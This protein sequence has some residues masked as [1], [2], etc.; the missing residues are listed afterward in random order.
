MST[1]CSFLFETC[2]Y[3][4][5]IQSSKHR[6]M[7]PPLFSAG[8]L[9]LASAVHVQDRLGPNSSIL[10]VSRDWPYD[11]SIQYTS[12]W[13]GAH[14]RPIPA[15]TPAEIQ[16]QAL[17]RVTN[18]VL[19]RQAAIE[20]ACGVIFMDGYD[21]VAAPSD[22]YKQLKGGYG[23]SEGFTLL[24]KDNFPV[25]MDITFGARYKTWSLN[26]PVYCGYLLRKFLLRG[27][28]TLKRTLM[29]AEEAFS[30]APSVSIVINCSGFGFGDPNTFPS[31]GK[32]R[33]R[34]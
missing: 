29:R 34:S 24:E 21:F 10:L 30:L 28:K 4:L 8:I 12:P 20:P 14:G 25:D 23:Q 27:G 9:G 15:V 5:V 1:C 7:I 22:A 11:E 6:L 33:R 3:A 16:H 31:R 26:S 13:A 2:A 18:R 19:A 17:S 32:P